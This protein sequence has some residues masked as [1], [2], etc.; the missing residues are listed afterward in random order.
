[1][2]KFRKHIGLTAKMKRYREVVSILVKHGF[3]EVFHVKYKVKHSGSDHEQGVYLDLSKW[4]RIRVAIEEL[5]T[6]FIKLGQM[7]SNRP[8]IMPEGLLVELRK[9]QESVPPFDGAQAQQIFFDDF[10]IQATDAFRS[11]NP[12]PIASASIAQVHEAELKT[13]ERVA[14]KIQRP[15]ISKQI[16]TD[17][18]IMFGILK[19]V[20]KHNQEIASLKLSNHLREFERSLRNELDFRIEAMNIERFRNNFAD[21]KHFYIPKVHHGFVSQN[22]LTMEFIEGA[23]PTDFKALK[24][25]QLS[26]AVIASRGTDF[27]IQQIFEFGFFH[28]DPHAGNIRI[29]KDNII[30]FLDYGM[31]GSI[32]PRQREL[33]LEMIIAFIRQ[34]TDALLDNLLTLCDRSLVENRDELERSLDELIAKFSYMPVKQIDSAEVLQEMMQLVYSYQLSLPGNFLMLAKS[35]VTI[36]GV[37]R[38][39]LPEFNFKEQIK[40][41]GK[42]LLKN[43]F[44]FKRLANEGFSTLLDSYKLMKNMPRYVKDILLLL[45]KGEVRVKIDFVE[46][47]FFVKKLEQ[48]FNRLSFSIIIAAMIVSS[49][50]LMHAGVPPLWNGISLIGAGGFLVSGFL[51]VA[52]YINAIFRNRI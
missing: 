22:V 6:T 39:L 10:K 36:E 14:V 42:T 9:L 46:I 45:K 26:P 18:E 13:G 32:L 3:G 49:A 17:V 31:V 19:L 16:N 21:K 38:E 5:G 27:I 44:D 51:V 40:P 37:A 52:Y 30:C 25:N 24:K 20:E 28:A 23:V 15:G 2:A 8:D 33:L 29:L 41:Y 34:D 7:L 4:E 47:Q 11:F 35:L 1:M 48:V 12:Q 43:K 50:L